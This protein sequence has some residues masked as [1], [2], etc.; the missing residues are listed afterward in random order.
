[1]AACLLEWVGRVLPGVVATVDRPPGPPQP[2]LIAVLALLALSGSIGQLDS[3][4]WLWE[5]RHVRLAAEVPVGGGSDRRLIMAKA[6]S[7]ERLRLAYRDAIAAAG[8]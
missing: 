3:R 6:H 4:R 7:F 2:T 5:R 8:L 1:M